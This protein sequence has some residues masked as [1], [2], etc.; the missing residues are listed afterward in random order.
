[1]YLL[2]MT[3]AQYG[4]ISVNGVNVFFYASLACDSWS[5]CI[6]FRTLWPANMYFLMVC[7]TVGLLTVGGL[8][9]L[10][11]SPAAC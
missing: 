1:M 8:P 2:L 3:K 10:W 6:H 7:L 4:S 5:L 11:T 9:V